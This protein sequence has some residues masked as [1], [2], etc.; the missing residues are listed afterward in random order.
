MIV[1][2]L[3][4]YNSCYGYIWRSSAFSAKPFRSMVQARKTFGACLSFWLRFYKSNFTHYWLHRWS[5]T[6]PLALRNAALSTKLP[7]GKA[8]CF[9][10]FLRGDDLFWKKFLL[11]A[12]PGSDDFFSFLGAECPRRKILLSRAF[13]GSDDLFFRGLRSPSNNL[14]SWFPGPLASK[15]KPRLQL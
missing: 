11:L 3:D 5:R 6:P 10:A 9:L 7:A 1:Q 13:P 2:F 14:L 15:P 4:P 8:A 12:F